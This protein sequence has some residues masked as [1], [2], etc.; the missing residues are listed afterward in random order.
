[1]PIRVWCG[2]IVFLLTMLPIN[3][4]VGEAQ[5]TRRPLTQ[6]PPEQ[7]RNAQ[8][9]IE[10]ATRIA[11]RAP[12][13]SVMA[14]FVQLLNRMDRAHAPDAVEGIYAQLRAAA[15][16]AQTLESYQR[17]TNSAHPLL[18]SYSMVGSCAAPSALAFCESGTP[19]PYGRGLEFLHF[20]R[21]R[22]RGE[23]LCGWFQ[24]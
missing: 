24:P 4:N 23:A 15:A 11:G 18:A 12:D 21:G 10:E 17:L 22:R 7:L 2:R 8:I 5:I 6:A 13:P 1:M 20:S 19:R 16:M 14:E 3:A 9:A